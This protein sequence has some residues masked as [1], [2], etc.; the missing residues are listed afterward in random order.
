VF[1]ADKWHDS[2]SSHIKIKMKLYHIV[3]CWNKLVRDACH[4]GQTRIES[5]MRKHRYTSLQY[6]SSFSC[7]WMTWQHIVSRWNLILPYCVETNSCGIHI[8]QEK[9]ESRV[10]CGNINAYRYNTNRLFRA[11]ILYDSILSRVK[12]EMKLYHTVSCQTNSY[13]MH[14]MQDKQ[15]SSV[16]C[17]NIDTF[18]YNTYQVCRA[19]KL[20]DSISSRVKL[21]MKFNHTYRYNTGH[22]VLWPVQV[23]NSQI[24]GH[25]HRSQIQITN[26]IIHIITMQAGHTG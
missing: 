4:A 16:W 5:L 12:V 13:G 22:T 20:H 21:E 3:S 26:L 8:I 1:C 18:H 11:D 6:I 23:K 10:W 15:A 9:Y 2:K 24:A 25:N 17:G 14:I 19:D 7:R